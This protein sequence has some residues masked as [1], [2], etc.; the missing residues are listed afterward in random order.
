MGT[1]TELPR[2]ESAVDPSTLLVE[3]LYGLLHEGAAADSDLEQEIRSLEQVLP[4]QVYSELIYLLSHLRFEEPEAR[5]HWDRIIAHRAQLTSR[6][7]TPE[8]GGSA[9][10]VDICA[11]AGLDITKAE[12]WQG[13]FDVIE[14]LIAELEAIPVE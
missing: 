9:S 1:T 6:L 3:Q 8:A 4:G 14:D 5:S 12:F 7:G 10:P 11:E 2:S 13:G